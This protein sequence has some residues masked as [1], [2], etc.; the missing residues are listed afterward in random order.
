[1]ERRAKQGDD[2][3]LPLGGPGARHGRGRAG[4]LEQRLAVQENLRSVRGRAHP[5][6]REG[7]ASASASEGAPRSRGAWCSTTG[8]RSAKSPIE[9]LDRPPPE[10]LIDAEDRIERRDMPGRVVFPGGGTIALEMASA[11]RRFGAEV[12]TML[13]AVHIHSTLGEAAKNAAATLKDAR[14]PEETQS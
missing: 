11:R 1:M 7:V 10:R 3:L 13:G 5:D 14:T 8:A 12:D 9:G 2:R 6:G 4:E